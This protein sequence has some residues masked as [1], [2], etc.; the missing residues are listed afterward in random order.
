MASS[1]NKPS[2]KFTI[3]SIFN[4]IPHADSISPKINL[5]YQ[6]NS[7][8]KPM[9]QDRESDHLFTNHTS[10]A[11]TNFIRWFSHHFQSDQEGLYSISWAIYMFSME[12]DRQLLPV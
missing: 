6:S 2:N 1:S 12:Y 10:R 3:P 9:R 8:Q 5:N 4:L 11:S 7:G